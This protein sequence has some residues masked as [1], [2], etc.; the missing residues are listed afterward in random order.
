[1]ANYKVSAEVSADTSKFKKQIQAAKRVSEKFK[2]VV[3][4]LKNNEVDANTANFDKKIDKSKSKAEKL[5]KMKIDPDVTVDISEFSRKSNEVQNVLD[6]INRKNIDP[7]IEADT[8]RAATN[9]NKLISIT[10][11][12]ESNK[13]D[14]DIDAIT[15]DAEKRI[16]LLNMNLKSIENSKATVEIRANAEEARRKIA[17][18]KKELLKLAKQRATAKLNVDSK[19]A[20][21]E[22]SRF[23]ALLRSIPNKIKTR[24]TIDSNGFQNALKGLNR[25]VD[26]FQD[27]MDRIAKSI[28]TF[29][30][31]GANTIQGT[32][33]SSFSAL[34]PV[35]GGLVP[36]IAAVGNATV[37]LGGGAVGAAG[38]FG[39]LRLG[40]TGFAGMAASAIQMLDKGMIQASN[41]TNEYKSALSGV[42]STWQS[43]VKENA[44][45]I[46]YAMASG[47]RSASNALNQMRPF[48]SGIAGLVNTNAAKLNTWVTSSGTAQRAFEAL[49]TT[50]VKI[51]G[52]LLS[53]GGHFGDGLVEIFTQLMPLF[54]WSSKGFQSMALSFQ[55]W[56]HSVE[57]SQAIQGFINY[58][59]TNLPIIG[60]IFKNTFIGI[61]N[62]FKAFAPNSTTIFQSLEKMTQKFAEWSAGIA[63]SDGFKK[64]VQ[65]MNENGPVIMQ[66]IGNIAMALVNF[67]IAMAPIA[68]QVLKMVTAFAGWI[69]KLFETH[70]AV[71]QLVG[72]SISLA[73][74]LMALVPNIVGITTFIGP[75]ITKFAALVTKVGIGK[76]TF[77]ALSKVFSLLFGKASLVRGIITIL[78]SAFGA[79]S[80]P[81]LAIIAVIGSLVAIFVYLWKTND[82]FREACINAWNVI[83]ETVS[84]VVNAIVS[85]VQSIWGGLVTWWQE[86]HTLIQNAAT[87]VWN[88]IKTVI[89]TVM[90][91]LGPSLQASWEVIKQAIIIVW[92]V[93]KTTVQLAINAVLGIIKVVMQL[94][95]GDWSGA[96]NTIKETAMNAWNIIKEGASNIFNALKSALSAIW[97]AIKTNASNVWNGLKTAVIA[98]VNA[99]KAGVQ[100]QWNA[101][102]SVTSSVFNAVKS[103][104]SSIWNGIKTLVSTVIGAIKSV[105]TSGFNAVK[106]AVNSVMNGVK[107]VVSSIW[108][109]VKSIF[110]SAVGNVK[111]VVSSGFNAARSTVS[112]IMG[113]I[114]ST[115]SNVWSGIRSTVSNAVHS[116]GSAMSNGMSSMRSAVSNGMSSVSSAVRNGISNAASAVR[117]GVYGMVSAG[118]DLARGIGRGIM[119]MA[120]YVMSRARELASRAVSAIKRALRIHSPSRV[121]R[122]E[123]GVFI[124]KGLTVGMM[125]EGRNTI[126]S[127][128]KLG[129]RVAGAFTPQIQTPEISGITQGIKGLQDS[130]QSDINASYNVQAEPTTNVIKIQLDLDDEAITAKVDGVHAT[131]DMMLVR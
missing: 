27:R 119:N 39:V 77:Q 94:I 107:S 76:A 16:R 46:F 26:V 118:A 88:A 10:K 65:Y 22:V 70:P 49:N 68:S 80:A 122:D 36:A 57:G 69:A 30:T 90:N 67:G 87:N 103:V 123:V 96:W 51:F 20:N 116:M 124:A 109:A 105:V 4:K 99:V 25:Q 33:L 89:M 66:L 115:I 82:G 102:K 50:G 47:I 3:D 84:G 131:K 117:N 53:A 62:I 78:A 18:T 95:T 63:K 121:M 112:N 81:V 71:A 14:I 110:S 54:E 7:K 97:E 72:V 48:L 29:G 35:I 24:L 126:K 2:K 61:F 79:L 106:S 40:I 55:K 37:A 127:A 101:I 85:F 13:V 43:I 128:A 5:D 9:L 60:N 113:A 83:K 38:A 98:V 74:A 59:K 92:E 75:L 73:G 52:N 108:N 1:M 15:A 19:L 31:I 114:K 120:G 32:L 56:A 91:V 93:I 44:S 8:K 125:N 86:N 58:T 42:K 11:E 129:D 34:I 12:L 45:Q 130:I 100:A 21:S 23:K 6:E 111:S 104:V 28:R 41:A 17:E 64:F